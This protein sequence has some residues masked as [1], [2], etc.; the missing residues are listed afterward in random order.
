MTAVDPDLTGDNP[1]I[2][3]NLADN[4]KS[5]EQPGNFD[6]FDSFGTVTP[7]SYFPQFDIELEKDSF[8]AGEVIIAQ[9]DNVGVVQSYDLRNE[10]LRVR[11][12][13]PFSQD[14]LIIGQSSQNKGLISSVDGISSK[15]K[16]GSN[17][18]TRKGWLKDTGKLNQFFQRMHDNDYYQYFSYSVRSSISFEKWN[19]IVSNL[20]HTAG[21]KKFSELVIDSY[22]PTVSG[23]QTAQDLNTVTAISDLTNIVDLNTVK[24]FDIAREKS[25]DVSGTLVSNEVLFNLPFLA[26]YQEF[27]GNRVLTIDDFS[28]QF[29]GVQRGFEL[30]TDNNPIFEIEFDGSDIANIGVGEGTINVTNHYFVSGE[31]IEY[32]PPGNN[33]A[34]SIQIQETDFGVGI[35]T[36]TLLPSQF[37]VI[38]QDNQKVRVATSATNALLF[39]P[40]GVGLTG[41]GIGSTHIFRAIEPNNRLLITVN[42]TI[43]SP[44]VGTAVTTALTAN[45]GI[46]STVIDVVGITSVFGGDILRVNDEVM[47]IA[48]SD[49]TNNTLTVRRGWMGSIEASHSS[50][51]VLTKQ[52]GNYAVVRN[53]LHFIEG[54][55]GN[56][57]VG[58]GTT[59]QDAGDADYTGLTTSSRFSGRIFLRSA[60]NQAFTTSFLPAYDNNF[61]YDDISDQ[62]N[63]INTS[64]TL[65]YEGQDIDNVTAEN[66]IILIDDIFQGPQR[67]GNVLT[68]IEGDYKLEAGGGALQLGFNGEVTDPSNHND[69]NVNKVPRG[70]VIV[71]VQSKEG[72]GFQPLV[73]AGA[74]ALVS[75][76]GT[77][78]N[79]SIGNTGSG[80]RSGLQ[81][82]SVG[83]QTASY[84]P[85]NITA[86][87]VATVVDGHVVGVAIT[88]SKV[89]YAPREISNIGYSSITGVTTVTTATPHNLQLGSEV[90]IVGAAFTCDYYPPV[91]VTNALYDTTTGIMTVTTG[92]STFTVTDFT[93][94]N[95]TGLATVTTLEPMKIVPMT[96]IGRSFS[97]AG[98]ALSCVGYGNTI[99][100]VGF[101]Y[102]N[103]NGIAEIITDADHGLS[104]GDDFKMRE[105]IFSCDVGGATGYGQTFTITQ[106]QYDNVTGLSTITTSDP[107]TG[108]IGIGSDIRLDNLEFSC[109][110]GSGITT[111]IFPDGTQGNT[112]TVTNVI[113][114]DQFELNVGIS[115]IPHTYV[116]NDAGQVTA[117]LTTT[118]F[119]DGSQGYFFRV[120]AVGTTTSFTVN[121]GPS[122]ISH[123]YVSGGVVQVGITTNI[124]PGNAQNSP[125]GDTFIVSAAPNWN[126]LTFNAGISTIPHNYVSGGSLTFGH[127]LKVGTDVALTGLAFTCSYDGGVGILTHPRVSDPTYCG[128][129]VTRINSIDEFEINV[130]VSTAESFYTSGGIVEEIILAPRP[131]NNSPSGQDPATNGT[132]I[133]KVIDEFSF[134]INS[135]P[136]PYTHAYKRCGEVRVPLDVVIDQPLPYFN[137]PLIYA[138]GNTGFG[139]GATVDL[140]PSLDS[141]ML[142]FEVNNFGYG[143]GSGEKLTVAIGG[144][145]GIQTF[146]AKTSNAILP[147]VAGGDYP[148]TLISADESQV[149]ITGI[150]TTTPEE[151]TAGT[152]SGS[153]GILT[154][155]IPGH[156][157]NTSNTISIGTSS[158]AFSCG[159]DGFQSVL[160]YPKPTDPIAGIDTAITATTT[161]TISLF[162]GISTLVKYPV[163]DATYDPDTG[164]SVLTIGPHNLTTANT[165]RLANESL[166]FKC[167][168]DGYSTIEA[169]PRPNKDTNIYGKSV[170]ITSY[171]A[172]SITVFAG[173]S[174]VGLRYP[175]TFVGVGSYRQFEL[176]ID[177]VFQSKFSG[178]NVGEF[179]VL[180]EIEQFFNGARR[181]FPLSVNGE[182]ISFF[183]KA[184]SGINLQSNLLVFVNDILQTPGEGY[185]FTGGS[186]IRFT[187]APK[188]GVAGFT[189]EGDRA[190]IFMYTGTESIDVRTVDVLPTVEVG[191]EIQL[192]S[193][194]DTTFIQDPRLVMDIKAADKVITNNYAGQGVTLNELFERPLSWSKQKVDKII[195]NVYIGKDRVYYEPVIN[196]NTNIISNVG[197][198][199]SSVYVYDVRPLFDNPFEGISANDRA[200]IEIIS[201]DRLEGATASAVVG[202]GGTIVNLLV[203]NIGYGYTTAPEVTIAKPYGDGTQAIGGV[204]I[205]AGGTVTSATVSAGGTNYFYGPMSSMTVYSQ[206][207]GFPPL[208][209]PNNVFRGARLKSE[210]GIGVGAIADIEISALN[211]SV[212]SINVLEGGANYQVGDRL[213]V[214]TFDNVGLATTSR[215]WALAAPIKFTVAAIEPPSVLIAPPKRGVE[216]SRFVTYEGDYGLV[217]GV[218]TTAIGAGT[219]IGVVFDLYIPMDSDLR[220]GINLTLP[221][222][223]TGDLFN[224]TETNFVSAAQTSLSADGSVIGISTLH[225]DMTYE[226][227][228]YYTKQSVIPAGLNGL[229]TTVGFGTTVTSVVVALQSAGSNNVVGVATTALYGYYTWGKVGLPVRIG[230]KNWTADH[231]GLQAGIGTNPI[232]RRK[233]PLKYLG[234]IS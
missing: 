167:S 134:I 121:V 213:F 15:Y 140:A 95:T 46:G 160:Y 106:F 136:S 219:S 99:G 11:S 216:E 31:L 118:K 124:F 60:L 1:T 104:G 215:K 230:P 77:I 39:N 105:L 116:E 54:P 19:P 50:S 42:G 220:S 6:S 94:D 123:T 139:T 209:A 204:T 56:L 3:Y 227:I 208:S 211:F 192:Y 53:T 30:F 170:G 133:V 108:V 4:L 157:F 141:T 36:T 13:I 33:K 228:D 189:T 185:Q 146:A 186:T 188:G 119:P 51:D 151:I 73:G 27:I 9:D 152:Y 47:L 181:L 16:I 205:G 214:D 232:L 52:S 89:F 217:V 174:P 198:A 218:G 201:Q 202:T 148:H 37:Y 111:T 163:T 187:E 113:A 225:G 67:L 233:N 34:N 25:I 63:G 159:S 154:L 155:T 166:L 226:C 10:Y 144:T 102:N 229:G 98:L 26:K 22:D 40:I 194:Q 168:L 199:D 120:Q 132:S 41:V 96:A 112:F 49:N 85:A 5:G 71:S 66:T 137:V 92:V 17:S 129:Q 143:Y 231:N 234:Y 164:F 147:V 75:A 100:V 93:Y 127:K 83:I 43:Q 190:K 76:A 61:I 135:G 82:V 183:A 69:I 32:V 207:T 91:D 72:Y 179:I 38:K 195:D 171:T 14:D 23:I 150:G 68:N 162:V 222:I 200:E 182:S 28:D 196:P 122:T 203:T 176:T 7:E 64:F 224:L 86:V 44:M 191:D 29:N 35:G 65:K 48:A 24:D 212:A 12:K 210:T 161:D 128:T 117:G 173:P 87:G 21:F 62:F 206:G 131:I 20:N 115:T 2:T 197:V 149:V 18:I 169:Y 125:L 59:A 58:L 158:M 45:V 84:G 184:N 110:G 156:S 81:T 80:Y 165:I 180:D 103:V 153:T 223:T 193:N 114:S 70:G 97:L 8:R 126:Q 90:Q 145:T 130:G 177:R 109:P 57:P 78:T 55:W 79:I 138:E 74:T 101:N 88:N 172:N 221:G 142:N 178:W 107:I 175:H